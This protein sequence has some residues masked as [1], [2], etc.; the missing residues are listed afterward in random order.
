MCTTTPAALQVELGRKG[1]E[2]ELRGLVRWR[3]NLVVWKV[4]RV[5]TEGR[6]GVLGGGETVWPVVHTQPRPRLALTLSV[7][8][9]EN[10]HDSCECTICSLLEISAL[11]CP[12]QPD[13]H[14]D[15]L[16]FRY[17]FFKLLDCWKTIS[18]IGWTR[19][20]WY[21]IVLYFGDHG[22]LW[23]YLSPFIHPHWLR[24][25]VGQSASS[26]RLKVT[27]NTHSFLRVW[28][29]VHVCVYIYIKRE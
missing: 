23:P 10:W 25:S 16:L 22:R 20:F 21:P 1:A 5:W 6:E 2:N 17:I 26:S 15:I 28:V 29:C 13:T 14:T 24:H 11:P 18:T 9:F 19:R 12:A 8:K 7:R 27:A 4:Y 3:C